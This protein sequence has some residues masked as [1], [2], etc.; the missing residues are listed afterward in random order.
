MKA[1]KNFS[2]YWSTNCERNKKQLFKSST[3]LVREQSLDI[4]SRSVRR[5]VVAAGLHARKTSKNHLYLKKSKRLSE[6][7]ILSGIKLN[8]KNII[9][10][11]SLRLILKAQTW[12]ILRWE[13]QK[14]K[15]S[16]RSVAKVQWSMREGQKWRGAVFLSM[17][18]GLS[19]K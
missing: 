3:G 8:G 13:D 5:R 10:G 9:S 16:S 17:D 6:T 19:I 1:V 12:K 14:M 4:S 18:L 15:D 7:I 11:M 2:P